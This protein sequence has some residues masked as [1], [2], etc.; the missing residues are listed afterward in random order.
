MI[1]MIEY[2][3]RLKAWGNSVGIVIPKDK[4]EREHLKKNQMVR[5]IISPAKMV[6][7]Q[8]IFGKL[9]NWKKPT[10]QITREIDKELGSK[11]FGTLKSRQTAQEFKDMVREGWK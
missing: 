1:D 9:K 5:V 6:R 11:F 10:G 3:T 7:V 4:I 8:D 2:E